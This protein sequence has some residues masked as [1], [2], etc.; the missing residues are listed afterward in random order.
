MRVYVRAPWP[1]VMAYALVRLPFS[2]ITGMFRV[3]KWGTTPARPAIRSLNHVSHYHPVWRLNVPPGWPAPPA[4][5]RPAPGWR[6]DPRWPAPPQGWQLWVPAHPPV[7]PPA[8]PSQP[9]VLT[10]PPSDK[11]DTLQMHFP[12]AGRW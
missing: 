9:P 4:G 1:L 12:A 3:L 7:R 11:D 8:W 2:I 10:R 6:P 5:W